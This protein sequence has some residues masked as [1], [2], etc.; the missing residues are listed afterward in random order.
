MAWFGVYPMLPVAV[1]VNECV[2]ILTWVGL[3]GRVTDGARCSECECSWI[4][5]I[6]VS[7]GA[8]RQSVLHVHMQHGTLLHGDAQD[9]LY[10]ECSMFCACK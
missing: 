3:I 10:F 9:S 7:Q 2:S 5:C 1:S 4:G 8:K 6:W